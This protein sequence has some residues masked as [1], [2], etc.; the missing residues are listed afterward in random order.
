MPLDERTNLLKP[1]T[2]H[3]ASYYASLIKVHEWKSR[4]DFFDGLHKLRQEAA[5]DDGSVANN[6]KSLFSKD[7]GEFIVGIHF[8]P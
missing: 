1:F 2:I 8:H 5:V 6:K 4:L 3:S 7:H